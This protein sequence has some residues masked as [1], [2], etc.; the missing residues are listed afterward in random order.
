MKK[1]YLV[2]SL[3]FFSATCLAQVSFTILEP[4]SIVGGYEF[5][6]NGDATGWGLGNLNDP[7]DA[8]TDTVVLAD[9]G[10]PGINAQGVPF[11][12]EACNALVNNVAGKIVMLYRYDGFSTNSCWGSTRVLNAQ[13]AGA[14]GVILVNRE[15]DTYGYPSAPDGALVTIPFAFITRSDGEL[16]RAKVDNGEDVVAFIGNKLGLYQNDV[17]MVNTNTLAPIRSAVPSQTSVDASE[18]GFDVGTMIYNY[19]ASDQ[20]GVILTAEVTGAGGTW[21]EIGGP[22]TILSGDSL[23][24]FT[25]GA[26]NINPFSFAAYP[27]GTYHLNYSL[28]IGVLDSSSFD[29]NLSYHFTVSDSMYTYCYMDT[30]SNHAIRNTFN[31]ANDPQYTACVTYDDPNGSRIAAEGVYTMATMAW[32]STN[33]LEGNFITAY[34]Y[35]WDDNF[36]D[37]N[38]ANFGF[39]ALSLLTEGDYYFDAGDDSQTVFIPFN[40]QIQFDD[41][42]RYLACVEVWNQEVWLGYNRRI[43]YNRHVNHYLQAITPIQAGAAWFGLGF[44][45]GDNT[46]AMALKIFDQEELVVDELEGLGIKLYPNPTN[47]VLNLIVD[48]NLQ[49]TVVIRDIA[50]RIMSVTQL[51]GSVN[52]LNVSKLSA[53]QYILTIE[54]AEGTQIQQKFNKL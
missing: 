49:G 26:N 48:E 42:Q 24:V 51:Q 19:G 44:V 30:L 13:N 14:V 3:A 33:P 5:T 31:R 38:D 52:E 20:T 2:A 22:Y 50:G 54:S 15:D 11:A 43:D 27:D 41:S 18:F 46:P 34:L 6:S 10:T 29:N 37:L 39:T 4:A 40:D 8:V 7:M 32:N 45:V 35:Q 28:D 1:I 47:N 36:A 21:T 9:D 53:G 17:G 25:G 23:D 12:N 16:I